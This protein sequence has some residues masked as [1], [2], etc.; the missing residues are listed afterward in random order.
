MKITK[1][2]LKRIIKEE[3]SRMLN[4]EEQVE[5]SLCGSFTLF[6]CKGPKGGK[7]EMVASEDL[8]A[9][10]GRQDAFQKA[11]ANERNSYP[12]A[13]S[14]DQDVFI[15]YYLKGNKETIAME[16]AKAIGATYVERES[17]DY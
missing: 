5:V 7:K 3:Y 11:L 1:S 17:E 4:E 14:V 9:A 12:D 8:A 2:T 13:T 16:Y 6:I 15:E 10:L